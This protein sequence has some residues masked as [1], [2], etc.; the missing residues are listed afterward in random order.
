LAKHGYRKIP[1]AA[2]MIEALAAA[3]LLASNWN[4]RGPFVNP[5]CGS[6]T[7]AIEAALLATHRYPGLLRNNY[8]FMHL[9]GFDRVMY[10]KMV[11][12]LHSKV[13]TVPNL[14]I[15]ATDI[16]PDAVD[17]ARINAT[18]AGVENLIQFDTCDFTQTRIPEAEN[19]VIY[20]N[21][22]YGE[23]LGEETELE[24]VYQSIGDFMKKQC[25][26]YT[27]YVFTGNLEL[28]KKIGLKPRYRT[29][30]YTTKMDS[31]LLM[32]ELY[33]GTKRLPKENSTSTE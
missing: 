4:R 7:I 5:M 19:G 14:A 3:T 26:G 22:E 13:I 1:G 29:E 24:Q 9:K 33:A 28:A 17:I 8:S 30:F 16:N 23:R 31:R 2:P 6:G 11:Q 20:F 25:G 18:A 12:T 32:Y 27:G 10:E 21:P 15:I